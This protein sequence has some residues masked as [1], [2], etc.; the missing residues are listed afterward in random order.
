[1]ELAYLSILEAPFDENP[2]PDIGD[3]IAAF[4]TLKFHY[5]DHASFAVASK[6]VPIIPFGRTIKLGDSGKDVIAVK[7]AL[8]KFYH[9]PLKKPTQ[10]FGPVAEKLVKK[11]QSNLFLDVDGVIGPTTLKQL[12]PYFDDYGFLL[13]TGFKPGSSKQ[14]QIRQAIVAYAIWGYN[15]RDSISYFQKRPMDHMQ[16]LY[17]LPESEDCSEFAEKAYKHG[18]APDPCANR[19][20]YNGYGN[21]FAMEANG[22]AVSRSQAKPGDLALY[23][24]HVAVVVSVASGIRVISMGSNPGPLLL[25]IDYRSDLH[26][27]RSYI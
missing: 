1:M 22:R 6:P 4:Q 18:K 19:P 24:E 9:E 26:S 20:P 13:Y 15:N 12:Q 5:P 7:R 14:E 27:I 16:D 3:G 17:Y 21:T 11:F 2:P 23:H 8:W 25:P 10:L